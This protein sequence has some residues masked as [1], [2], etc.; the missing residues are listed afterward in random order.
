ME[1]ASLH[2]EEINV[3]YKENLDYTEKGLILYLA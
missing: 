1:K 3:N 2:S